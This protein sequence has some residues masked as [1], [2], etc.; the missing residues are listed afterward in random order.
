MAVVEN[1]A[2]K[3]QAEKVKATF[4]LDE[5]TDRKFTEIYIKAIQEHGRAE[6]SS[7]I[8]QAID[9]MHRLCI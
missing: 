5:E 4:Y 8:C 2:H 9:M 7:L 1:L 6:K 3:K